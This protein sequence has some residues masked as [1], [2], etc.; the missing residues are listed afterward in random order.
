MNPNNDGLDRTFYKNLVKQNGLNLRNVPDQTYEICVLAVLQNGLS[1][2]FVQEQTEAICINAVMQ[3]K[4]AMQ[5]VKT[6]TPRILQVYG[7]VIV[8]SWQTS[9]YVLV[10]VAIA[11]GLW[12]LRKE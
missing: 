9:D 5:F 11:M 1:L 8:C 7:I 3:N 10:S 4:D 6:V 2:E 12:W